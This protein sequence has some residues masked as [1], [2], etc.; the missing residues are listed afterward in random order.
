MASSSNQAITLI[1]KLNKLSSRLSSKDDVQANNEALQ[2]SKELTASLEEPK[3]AAVHLAFSPFIAIAARIA[4][5]LDLFKLIV[6]HG[7]PI[8]SQQLAT[9]SGGEELLIIR[10]LRPMAAT[11][12]VKEVGERTW[13]ATPITEAMATEE[14]AAGHR[15]VGMIV[16]AATKAPKWLKE[17]GHRCPTNPHDGFIQYAYQTKLNIFQLFSTMPDLMK[18]FN[19]FMGNTMGARDYW[20]DWFPVQERLI[21]GAT[22]ESALLVDVGAGKGH[23]LLAFHNKYPDQG[24]LVLQD[25]AAVTDNLEGLDPS[26]KPMAYDFFAEQP[27]KG[28]RAYFYHHILHDWSNEKCLEILGQLKKAMK[29]GYSKLLLHEMIIPEQGA[30]PFHAML[31]MTMMTFNSGMERSARQWEELLD[32][33]GFE[34]VKIWPPVQEDADGIVEAVLKE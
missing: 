27:V 1:E 12:F 7:G 28:A 11:G 31:D 3:N 17:S 16:G 34:V 5:N 21:D 18:D 24:L 29:P 13:E 20:V 23:D 19:L 10:A 15:T 6:S 30:S 2:L 9:L 14:I 26:I 32:K 22:K 8:T 33:A 25:L 4:V